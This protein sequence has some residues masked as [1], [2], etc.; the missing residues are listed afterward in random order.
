[1]FYA[2]TA[3]L[4]IGTPYETAIAVAS[5]STRVP[6]SLIKAVIAHESAWD[7][8]AVNMAD[9]SYGL[10]QVNTRAH[11]DV[12]PAQMLDPAANIAYGTRYLGQQLARYG[13]PA[14]ISAYNAGH[15][16]SGNA[17]YVADVQAYEAWYLAND[18]ASGAPPGGVGAGDDPFP[19]GRGS[20]GGRE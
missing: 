17:S 13:V 1:M 14:G 4:G 20:V 12:T 2:A 8:S 9:P 15:P 10:M 6:V 19:L 11:P 7:P 18:P 16:I 5:A 3:Q